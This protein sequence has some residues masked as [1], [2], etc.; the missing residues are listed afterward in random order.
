MDP[1]KYIVTGAG[2]FVG[3]SIAL[4]LLKQGH[5]VIGLARGEYPDLTTA[6]VQM[7]QA[8]LSGPREFLSPLFKD[9]DGVFH[10]A[11]KVDMWGPYQEFFAGNV[12]ATRNVMQACREQGVSKLIYTSS[13]SVVADGGNLRGIDEG[14]PYPSRYKA[15]YPRTKAQAEREVLAANQGSG[16][17]T[18]ALRPH[19]IFGPGDRNFVPT[20][21]ERARQGRLPQVGDG[22]NMVDFT[23]IDDCTA[24]HLCALKAL[25]GN[26]NARGRAFFISQGEPTP[27]WWWI[28]EVVKR[29]GAPEIRRRLPKR[30][31]MVVAGGCELISRLLPGNPQPLLTRFLVS[32]MATDHWFN[33]NAAR[34]ELGYAPAST[35]LDALQKTF[36]EAPASGACLP[37][38]TW[39][40]GAS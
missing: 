22:K 12:L 11:A 13:P 27:M 33:I 3:R 8:D 5:T 29:S 34:K 1:K 19:L 2:G 15:F 40:A 31:G 14:Y 17:F 23:F 39:G 37:S 38:Y 9:A 10:V 21:V 30:I 35:I 18:I 20:I 36:P 26:P 28:R 4:A 24:A 6:G 25:D 16:F 7:Y 32:E